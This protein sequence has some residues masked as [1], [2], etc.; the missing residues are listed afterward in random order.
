MPTKV[1]IQRVVRGHAL[2]KRLWH[3]AMT[4]KRTCFF[5]W[6]CLGK[7]PAKCGFDQL[8]NG[9]GSIPIDTFLVG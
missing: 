7:N 5:S 4:M 6:E 3:Q 9:Y 8:G 1:N 2:R